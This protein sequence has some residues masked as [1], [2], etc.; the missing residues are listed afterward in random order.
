[1]SRAEIMKR[2]T[3]ASPCLKAR[4]AGALF[5][6]L[7]LTAACFCNPFHYLSSAHIRSF[8]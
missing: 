6:L 8:P 1:M 7:L 3:E 4:I 5:L 2:I